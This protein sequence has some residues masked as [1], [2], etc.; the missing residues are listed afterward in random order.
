MPNDWKNLPYKVKPPKGFLEEAR[1]KVGPGRQS[2]PA[3]FS[4][5]DKAKVTPSTGSYAETKRNALLK[6]LKGE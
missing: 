3:D 4:V 2:K 5:L 6:A 1:A